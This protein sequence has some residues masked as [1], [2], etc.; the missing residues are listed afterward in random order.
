M[1]RRERSRGAFAAALRRQSSAGCHFS[2][3]GDQRGPRMRSWPRWQ[4]RERTNAQSARSIAEQ[5]SWG[6][7][8]HGTGRPKGESA[9]LPENKPSADSVHVTR[10]NNALSTLARFLRIW[11]LWV[12]TGKGPCEQM[13]SALPLRADIAQCSRHVR[14]VPTDGVIGRPRLWIAEDFGC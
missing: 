6:N 8:L 12:K 2:P 4:S 10:T 7:S 13:F 5:P 9:T 11:R 1:C 14:F 3:K